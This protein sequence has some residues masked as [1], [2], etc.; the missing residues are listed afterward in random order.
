MIYFIFSLFS[1][2]L[3][4]SLKYRKTFYYLQQSSYNTKNRYIKWL[5]K[6]AKTTFIT[7]DLYFVL[8]VISY[9]ILSY[10][11]FCFLTFIFFA[12][13]FYQ[14]LKKKKQEKQKKP[15]VVTHRIK[16][17]CITTFILF[18]LLF[19]P[20]IITFNTKYILLYYLLLISFTYFA[21]TITLLANIINKP[22]E[23]IVYY[24]YLS[25]AQNKLNKMTNLIKIGITGSYGKTTTKNILN[26]LI[27]TEYNSYVTPKSFNTPYGLISAINNDLSIFDD[28]FIAE[29]G[30]C[31]KNDIK[32]LTNFINP[33]YAIITN[34]GVAHYE[35]FKSITNIINTKFELVENLPKDGVAI[36]NKDDKN[37]TEYIIKNKC[38]VIWI[39]ID[40]EAD[41]MA[42]NIN[43]TNQEMTF[44]IYF[45]DIKQTYSFTTNILGR[46]N[47]YNILSAIALAKELNIN[48]K[49]LQLAIANLKPTEHRLDIKKISHY[50]IIDDSFNSNP[51]GAKEALNILKLMDG[52]KI[53]ITPGMIELGKKQNKLNYELGQ[54]IAK[55]ADI[56]ILVGQKQTKDVLRGLQDNNYNNKN[57]Y[58]IDDI[59]KAFFIIEKVRDKNIETYILLENDLPDIFNE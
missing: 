22:V 5:F 15:F 59:K 41:I 52:Q 11:F 45:K 16:R 56:T 27:S 25:M 3:Y 4:I 35:I 38:K 51:I 31:S 7:D 46:I 26:S 29:M 50:N 2:I 42:K 55:V 6:N 43:I 58:V 1:Y 39:G 23:L 9:Y 49:K 21:P 12:F 57:I 18:L 19:I 53:V 24:H 28:I 10:S 47:I 13:L 34:I 44:D 32:K 20:I 8:I 30:A 54:D 14:E 17:L 40:N 37:I 33:K 48:I 36:L